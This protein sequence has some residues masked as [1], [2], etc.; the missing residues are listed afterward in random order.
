MHEAQLDRDHILPR[1]EQSSGHDNSRGQAYGCLHLCLNAA[2]RQAKVS[3]W[4]PGMSI[5]PMIANIT[6]GP[7]EVISG[8]SSDSSSSL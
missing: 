7:K 8:G 3:E 2:H 1:P 6:S 5:Q 4:V